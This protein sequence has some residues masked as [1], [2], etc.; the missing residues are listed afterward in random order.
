MNS[1]T[2]SPNK[3]SYMA[4]GSPHR[5]MKS[6]DDE[7]YIHH[8]CH[9]HCTLDLAFTWY[10]L[11]SDACVLL[12]CTGYRVHKPLTRVSHL[13]STDNISF[14][15]VC[16]VIKI[17]LLPYIFFIDPIG[18]IFFY[19]TPRYTCYITIPVE[20]ETWWHQDI[21]SCLAQKSPSSVASPDQCKVHHCCL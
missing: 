19:I 11:F 4:D 6:Y 15:L 12:A 3:K 1:R 2:P 14:A 17:Y 8:P 16:Y 9:M 13:G 7:W 10:L 5:Y 18:S 20:F 21:S